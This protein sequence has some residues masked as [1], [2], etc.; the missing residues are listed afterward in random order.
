[1]TNLGRLLA[2]PL[3][4]HADAEA[5]YR[6]AVE[7]DPNY[8]W[9]WTNL[10]YLLA[11]PLARHAEAEGAYRKAVELDPKS[12]WAWT[13]LGNLL[14]GPLERH[15][16]AE[17]AFRKAIEIDP[18][19][20][21]SW[22]N[23]GNLLADH[24]F[25]PDEAEKAYEMAMR[26]DP[27]ESCTV[28][29]LAYLLLRQEGSKAVAETT[30]LAAIG[31]L[32]PHGAGLLRAFHALAADNFGIATAELGPVLKEGHSELF[33]VFRDDLLRILQ[34]AADRG[35]GDKL[36]A[37]LKSSDFS[38]RYWP[39]HVAFEAYLH[40]QDRLMDVNP[41]VRSGARRLLA[42]MTRRPSESEPKK[43]PR[44]KKAGT[45]R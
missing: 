2:G 9:A 37:W 31:A 5:A 33:T 42:E 4:R 34:F 11:G 41:E 44:R 17:A 23:L 18:K 30:Y 29:N 7:F 22:I 45:V 38:D 24:L 8:A 26:I 39:L 14:A 20:V 16:E 6:K 28:A 1:M 32:P 35:N 25:R 40:G 13:N 36:L 10:G 3:E 21:W 43:K 15:A 19:D 27:Q 12:A